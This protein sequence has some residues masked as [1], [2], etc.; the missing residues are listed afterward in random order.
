MKKNAEGLAT[1]GKPGKQVG[2]GSPSGNRRTGHRRETLPETHMK[3]PAG[4]IP[5]QGVFEIKRTED[6]G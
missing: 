4:G 3:N 5:V 2:T 1:S 6:A